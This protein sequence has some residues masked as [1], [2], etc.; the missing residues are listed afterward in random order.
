MQ[1]PKSTACYQLFNQRTHSCFDET[2]LKTGAS[3]PQVFAYISRPSQSDLPSRLSACTLANSNKA[4]P[5]NTF[6]CSHHVNYDLCTTLYLSY[7]SLVL[8]LLRAQSALSEKKNL[9][10][11]KMVHLAS[12]ALAIPFAPLLN[13]STTSNYDPIHRPI[14][15]RLSPPHSRHFFPTPRQ[16]FSTP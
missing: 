12:L 2:A 4:G 3:S 1:L 10:L 14:H 7:L 9:V 13:S 15:P 11:R 8:T 16:P 5:G 6:E